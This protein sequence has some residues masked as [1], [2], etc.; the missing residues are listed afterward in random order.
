M[1]VSILGLGTVKLGRRE[2]VR[3]P[4]PFELPSDAEAARL[5]DTAREL[6]FNL[7]DTAP[8]YGTSEARLGRLLLDRRNDWLLCTK[9]GENFANGTSTYD[10]SPEHVQASVKN[11]LQSLHTDRLDIVLIH[12][13]GNDLD[14]LNGLGTLDCLKELKARGWIR[15]VGI[16]HK[17]I[18]GAERALALDCDVIMATLNLAEQSEVDLIARAGAAGCGVLVKKAMASGHSGTDS[19]RFAAAA[20]GVSS[21][22]IGTINPEHL[23][24]NAAVVADL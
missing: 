4:A 12:S 8:A 21:V 11:S 16:S 14:I 15:A 1:T 3:Y 24:E 18:A 23:R 6:G 17:T 10:F 9:V 2:G 7:I 5:L 13:D 19:L 20:E 22:V